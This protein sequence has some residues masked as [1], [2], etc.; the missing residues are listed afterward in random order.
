[1]AIIQSY[2]GK[3]PKIAD[4]AFIAEN[5]VIIGDVEIGHD[6]SIWYGCV[7]RGD[8]NYIRIGAGSNIQ[9]NS[10]IHVSRYHGPTIVGSG[11][12]VGHKVLLHACILEDHSFVGMG[13]ILLDK[14]KVESQAMIAAGALLAP[15]KVVPQNQIWA[16]NPAKF[17]R[18]LRQDETDYIYTSE[19]NYIE[20]A[21]IYKGI[22]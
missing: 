8:V 12:T 19:K 7:I 17:F 11:V 16:G 21:Q 22:R 14:S 15:N 3:H 2:N 5:A 13:A 4:S 10:T 18:N 6:A 20:L 1:M 9:D